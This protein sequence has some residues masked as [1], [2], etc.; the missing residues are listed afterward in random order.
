MRKAE[1]IGDIKISGLSFGKLAHCIGS[2]PEKESSSV[3]IH[4]KGILGELSNRIKNNKNKKKQTNEIIFLCTG[5]DWQFVLVGKWALLDKPDF[6]QFSQ[7][8][9]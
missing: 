8:V 2:I 6:N 1:N 3:A 4:T 5:N 7:Q 9:Q